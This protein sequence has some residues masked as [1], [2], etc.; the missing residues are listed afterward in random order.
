MRSSAGHNEL[1]II[2]GRSGQNASVDAFLQMSQ[3]QP[4]PVQSQNIRRAFGF[5]GKPA[6]PFPGLQPEVYLRVMAKGFKMAVAGN[7]IS[8][9]L[10][11]L[12]PSLAEV[13]DVAEAVLNNAL[14]D[15]V[16]YL[17]HG[18]D[19][20]F[21]V[22]LVPGYGKLRQFIAEGTELTIGL[23]IGLTGR[24]LKRIGDHGGN[25]GRGTVLDKAQ[26]LSRTGLIQP[27]Q[28]HDLTGFGN[29]EGLVFFTGIEADLRNLFGTD[30]L[31]WGQAPAEEAD[32][33]QTLP[34]IVRGDLED[35]GSEFLASS[36]FRGIGGYAV[37]KVLYALGFQGRT[38][39]AGKA[40]SV[41]DQGTDA[42]CGK[43][44]GFAIFLQSVFG[45]HGCSLRPFYAFGK[46]NAV[47][48]E[49]LSEYGH[50]CA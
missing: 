2:N 18:A 40:E 26:A 44:T 29:R 17:A 15:F 22:F 21:P 42:F 7:R 31:S 48:G 1:Q 13:H 12:D 3:D 34:L 47:L 38:E 35:P 30:L 36:S 8:D 28:C 14:K 23:G 49:A 16:L 24:Q 41:P 10:M 33:G 20:Y 43:R 6:S 45:A 39:I 11:V 19:P 37:K 25:K 4:L 9:G 46:T 32:M 5:K 27:G 50:N